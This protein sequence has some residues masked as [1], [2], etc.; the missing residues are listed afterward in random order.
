MAT[1]V[2]GIKGSPD[3]LQLGSSV[4]LSDRSMTVASF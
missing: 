3:K 2:L 4:V 1:T